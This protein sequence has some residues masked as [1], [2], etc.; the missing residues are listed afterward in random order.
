VPLAAALVKVRKLL[1]TEVHGGESLLDG[2]RRMLDAIKRA[3]AAVRAQAGAALAMG[4]D[5]AAKIAADVGDAALGGLQDLARDAW[6][7]VMPPV[8]ILL[9]LWALSEGKL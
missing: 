1:G 2:A 6:A 4:A 3:P 7:L 5:K 9:A 8:L